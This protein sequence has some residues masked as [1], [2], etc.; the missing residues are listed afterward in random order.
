VSDEELLRIYRKARVAIVPLRVGAGMKGKVVEALHHG[1]PLVTTTV[2]AQGLQGL[3]GIAPVSDDTPEL[4]TR[5]ISLLEDDAY[6]RRVS[7]SERAFMGQ[8]FS[9]QAMCDLL[10][11][12]TAIA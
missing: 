6:W 8:R 11:Q 3:S 1:V 12:D 7:E 9:R 5:V 2:G 4:A 10:A